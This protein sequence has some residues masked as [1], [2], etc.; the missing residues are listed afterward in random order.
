MPFG[1]HSVCVWL[2][3]TVLSVCPRILA[4]EDSRPS[5][6][7]ARA[8]LLVEQLGAGHY[9]DRQRAVRLLC[10]L[11]LPAIPALQRGTH[12]GDLEIRVRCRKIL[13]HLSRLDHHRI[14]DAFVRDPDR[15]PGRQL[16]GWNR[17]RK[18]VGD[19]GGTRELMAEM[20]RKEGRLFRA[21]ST[22]ETEFLS[23][24]ERR[25]QEIQLAYRQGSQR[26]IDVGSV[27]TLLFF[28]SDQQIDVPDSTALALNNLM[29]YNNLKT[30]LTQGERKRE[31]RTLLGLWI[32][33]PMTNGNY[34]RLLLA[35]RYDLKQGLVPAIRLVKQKAVGLQ[36][37]YAILAIGK[38][39]GREHLPLL[40]KQ[41]QNKSVLSRSVSGG[42][43]VYSCQIRDVALAISIHITKQDIGKYGFNRLR[44]NSTYLYSPNSAGFKNSAERDAAFQRF[45]AWQ[46]ANTETAKP[47]P[48][49]SE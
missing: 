38:L 2:V 5:A 44:K 45:G 8:R 3:G 11:G 47:Q 49:D 19:D 23:Q 21:W 22:G 15:D 43:V 28:G 34:Q 1:R 40:Q 26:R 12:R 42:K 17:F 6:V 4:D 10:E 36:A 48:V 13:D 46:R 39:G 27:A 30:E 31:L 33:R 32:E 35:M 20:H 25:C 14:L 29:Y 7:D 24:F 41:F 37:Q 9:G 16:P 18:Q